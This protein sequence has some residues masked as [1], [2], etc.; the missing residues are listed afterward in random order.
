MSDWNH[1]RPAV[2]KELI[3]LRTFLEKLSTLDR[4][5]YDSQIIIKLTPTLKFFLIDVNIKVKQNRTADIYAINCFI[6]FLNY[7]NSTN[8]PED[9]LKHKKHLMDQKSILVTENVVQKKDTSSPDCEQKIRIINLRSFALY[10]TA[11]ILY[12]LITKFIKRRW[13]LNH[14]RRQ[15]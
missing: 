5:L 14:Q 1:F 4:A 2:I 15:D 8:T 12:L 9:F 6:A 10:F 3:R 11:F 13:S 7:K